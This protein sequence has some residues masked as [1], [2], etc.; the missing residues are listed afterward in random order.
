MHVFPNGW[1]CRRD[2]RW[3]ER[4]IGSPQPS[5]SGV[6]AAARQAIRDV[7]PRRIIFV[8]VA[9]ALEAGDEGEAPDFGQRGPR[10]TPE[11]RGGK[12]CGGCGIRR[13]SYSAAVPRSR[14]SPTSIPEEAT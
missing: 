5:A 10:V 12:T 9:A 3:P 13:T 2:V 4:D 6:V 1:D 7:P 14:V 8:V 11:A